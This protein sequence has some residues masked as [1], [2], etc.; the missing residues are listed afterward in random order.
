MAAYASQ[1]VVDATASVPF[2]GI[3]VVTRCGV[4][5]SFDAMAAGPP[6]TSA[7][8]PSGITPRWVR[9]P[10][11]ARTESGYGSG[12]EAGAGDGHRSSLARPKSAAAARVSRNRPEELR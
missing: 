9:K 2:G 7:F 8:R 4:I 5:W 1:S 3:C 11:T 12:H 6:L 10:Q